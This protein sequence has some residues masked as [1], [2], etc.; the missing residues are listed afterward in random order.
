MTSPSI[1]SV[2]VTKLDDTDGYWS[3][4]VSVNGDTLSVDRR[5]GSWQAV[6][7]DGPRTRTFH[8]RD[9]HPQL[10]ALLQ[11]KVRPREHQQKIKRGEAR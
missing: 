1:P 2:T 11:Q 7:R 3:A 8:R 4:R 9:V 5:Y 10:A 6:I